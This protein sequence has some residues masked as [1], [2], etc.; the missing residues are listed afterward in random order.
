MIIR[1]DSGEHQSQI[2]AALNLVTSTI[3]TVLKN[4]EK[5]LSSA[6]ATTSNSATRNNI[7]NNIIEEINKTTVYID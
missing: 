1:L 7:R 2:S 5:K 6:T 4:K 3:R